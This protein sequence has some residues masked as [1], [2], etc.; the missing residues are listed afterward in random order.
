M[1]TVLNTVFDSQTMTQRKDAYFHFVQRRAFEFFTPEGA[2]RPQVEPDRRITFWILP[3]L[4]AAEDAAVRELALK[5][6]ANDPCWDGWNIFT[7]SS[8]A[9]NLVR[10]RAHLTP[11]LIARS[12]EHLARFTDPG[13]G[14]VPSSGAND[15]MFHGYNDNMPAMATRAMIFTGEVLGLVNVLDHG[16]F[17]LE[18]LCANFQRRGLLSEYNSSTYTPITLVA[19]M[20]IAELAQTEEAREMAEACANR[21]LLDLVAHWHPEMGAPAGSSS[22]AYL[23]D[24]TITL[25][26]QNALMW[27]LGY[28]NCLDPID[29]L[30]GDVYG[31]PLHHGPDNAFMTAQFVECFV[32]H[33][34]RVRQDIVDFARTPREYPYEIKATMDSGKTGAFQTR[35]YC[36]SQWALGTASGD[37]WAAQAGHHVTLRGTLLRS[38]EP[39]EWSSRVA[40]WH[41]LQSGHEDWGDL[42]PAYNDTVTPTTHVNDYGQ[43]HTAQA[44]GS[45]MVV[46]H[47]GTSLYDKTID[48][49]QFVIIA[50]LFGTPPDEMYVNENP[51]TDWAGA[52]TSTDWHFLRFGQ[53][54]VGIRAAGVLDEVA[55][56]VR[57]VMKDGYL[58]L[59]LPVVD[60]TPTVVTPDFRTSL[61]VA[62]VL[63]M[64]SMEDTTFQQFRT[65]C[66]TTTWECYRCFYRNGRY[67]GRH[68]ELQIVDSIDPE[69]VRFIA[70]DGQVET[71]T[72][73]TAPGITPSMTQLFPDGC[74]VRPRRL[75]FDPEFVG[76]P[77][78]PAKQQVLA[79]D[80]S[81]ELP[82]KPDSEE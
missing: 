47:L 61:D 32:P 49:L 40:L 45:A 34:S 78:Y 5:M 58:R 69:G 60:G 54:F 31:G 28:P 55:L 66:L 80:H 43:W 1:V 23:P 44:G 62:Y 10:D 65:D 37:M 64:A 75:V 9:A 70:V 14:R 82:G 24:Y 74:T 7:T 77:F 39:S 17:F 71:P 76:S 52:G 29:M 6:Y 56:P 73:F 16:L 68:G 81:V 53:V 12:E 11:E 72:F 8:I 22:R 20:D 19:L 57:R 3:A 26:T 42:I 30:T 21:V 36:A 67:N 25:S 2:Y 33:F 18:G 27:Y 59:E 13:D 38:D 46:G 35:T 50:S 41:Y 48:N 15:Y 51:L 63:E 4:L 79:M